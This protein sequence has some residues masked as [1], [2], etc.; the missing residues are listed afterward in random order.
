MK[1]KNKFMNYWNRNT[2]EE[3]RIK[4]IDLPVFS[5]YSTFELMNNIFHKSFFDQSLLFAY[6]LLYPPR[7]GKSHTRIGE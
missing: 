6:L 5:F 7:P 3:I 2:K 4:F 1:I